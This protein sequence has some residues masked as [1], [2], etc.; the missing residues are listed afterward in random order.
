MIKEAIEKVTNQE[1]LTYNE[2]YDAINSIMSG[3]CSDAEVASLLTAL[4]MKGEVDEEISGSAA[5]MRDKALAMDNQLDSLDIVGTGGDKSFSFNI[6]STAAIVIAAAGVPVA[7]HG[8]RSASSKSGAADCIEALGIKLEQEPDL[9]NKL[10]EDVGICFLYAQTYHK[11]MKYV[12]PVRKELGIRTVFNLLGPITNP[13]RPAYQVLGVYSEALVE[14]MAKVMKKLGVKRGLVVYGQDVMDEISISAPTTALFFDGDYEDRF[15]INPEDF[16][17]ADYEKS[18]IVGGT[19]E[20][21]AQITRDVLS[22]KTQ[23][24]KRAIVLMNAGAGLYVAGKAKSIQEGVDLAAE[25]IDSG[26]AQ[27][28]LEQYI[29]LSQEA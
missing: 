22:G 24:A 25:T 13:A 28:L 5:A 23:G 12:G 18:E 1:N 17:F 11:S 3:K 8:N 14:P 4:A 6:S 16:G 21:N 26:K 27:N 7:K 10:L 20:E 29:Q 15:E 19:A 2:T 9:A